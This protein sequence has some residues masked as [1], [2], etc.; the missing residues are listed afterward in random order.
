MTEEFYIIWEKDC[1]DLI[2]EYSTIED[3]RKDLA[4]MVEREK[5]N[6]ADLLIL[7]AVERPDI[8]VQFKKL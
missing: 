7:K 6:P 2:G 4:H 5:I 8:T 1:K 3:A